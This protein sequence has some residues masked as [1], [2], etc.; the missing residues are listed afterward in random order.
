[1]DFPSFCAVFRTVMGDNAI[2]IP[3][4]DEQIRP[5]YDLTHHLLAVNQTLNLTAIRDEGGVILHHLADSLTLLPYLPADGRVL[6]VGCGGGFP[7]LPLA[8]HR[9]DL[10]FTGLDSTE[11]KVRYV[12]ETATILGLSN[13]RVLLG[14]AEE[15]AHGPMRESFEAVTARAVAALPVLSELCLPFVAVGGKFLAM[16]SQRGEAELTAAATAI[17]RLGGIVTAAH[18]L[19]LRAPD[20]TEE[21]R[22]IIEIE[23]NRP[24]P[25][26]YPRPY[27]K[28]QK[29][30]L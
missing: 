26:A 21:S 14:R 5:F 30:P 3:T 17:E 25:A 18:T 8:L 11:K 15:L 27:A 12:E 9:P 13:Y 28:I 7:S 16:K 20:G 2:S 1:M 29:K 19:T 10:A 6:D 24:T 23:K 22:L 4:E